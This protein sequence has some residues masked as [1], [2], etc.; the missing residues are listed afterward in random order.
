M[1]EFHFLENQIST[2]LGR[3]ERISLH[4]GIWDASAAPLHQ[5]VGQ[6]TAT[7][8]LSFLQPI[9]GSR[10]I[11]RA[12]CAENAELHER[13]IPEKGDFAK[14]LARYRSRAPGE[15]FVLGVS[16]Y[17]IFK[18]DHIVEFLRTGSVTPRYPERYRF[19]PRPFAQLRANA[20]HYVR[21]IAKEAREH[22]IELRLLDPKLPEILAI[23]GDL[24]CSEREAARLFGV[25][26]EHAFIGP[27]TI[28][29]DP[30]HYCNTNCEHCWVH[31]PDITHTGEFLGRKFDFEVFT[32]L[33]D[34]C[35]SM[36]VDGIIFQGDGEPL[37][38]KRFM[39]MVQYARERDIGVSFFSNGIL[40]TKDV[41]EK[42]VKYGVNEVFCSFPAASA[43]TWQ[44]INTKCDPSDFSRVLQNLRDLSEAKR[45]AA[46]KKPIVQVTH[47]I[48]T[49]NYHEVMQM[50]KNGVEVGADKVRYY[51]IRLDKNIRYLQLKRKE[52]DYLKAE[53]PK[54]QEFFRSK[55]TILQHN[56]QF[57]LENYE[58]SD[59]SWAKDT[60][61]KT[62][63]TIGY[64]FC[65]IPAKLDLSLC[66]HLRTIGSLSKM[67]FKELW[68]SKH[69]QRI[70]YQAKHMA[71]FK[72]VPFLNGVRL[73]DEHC[74][75]CDNHQRLIETQQHIERFGLVP[76]FS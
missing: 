69:Y 52:I 4:E 3:L 74:T 68:Y 34:D 8:I 44:K 40:L 62:G 72:N 57:Q 19:Q 73:Y 11:A 46:A 66:C 17:N 37:A 64:Y 51:L 58:A 32:R 6:A 63:C 29:I 12:I 59:G 10:D 18:L 30:H 67:G 26:V 7:D 36:E 54:I 48:H 14:K 53:M 31:T 1:G 15:M 35:T 55:N 70:R 42:L 27:Q 45:R 41:G 71:K 56:I 43:R 76:Y 13:I 20:E 61:L 2:L 21:E 38:Y 28:V 9:S 39:D 25:I 49:M 50:A 24:Q 5:S 16:R 33:I 60:F 75:H 65:L 22:G 23:F 47:V